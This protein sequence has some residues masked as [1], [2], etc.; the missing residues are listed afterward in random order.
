VENVLNIESS[1]DAGE[2][3]SLLT[4][5]PKYGD[6]NLRVNLE[7]RGSYEEEDQAQNTA[8]ANLQKVNTGSAHEM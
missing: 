8:L 6:N 7:Q 3:K 4:K 5:R 2:T 1:D